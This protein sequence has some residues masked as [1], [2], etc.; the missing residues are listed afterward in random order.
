MSSHV[1]KFHVLVPVGLFLVLLVAGVPV[2]TALVVGMSSGCVAMMF[3]MMGGSR[4]RPDHDSEK[5]ADADHV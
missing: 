5:P 1:W 4:E 2:G 3:M